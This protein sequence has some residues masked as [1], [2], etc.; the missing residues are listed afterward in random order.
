[1]KSLLHTLAP[2]LYVKDIYKSLDF[3]CDVLGFERPFIWGDPPGFAM[4]KREH[5]IIMLSQTNDTLKI[6][7]KKD[8]WDVYVWVSDVKFLHE[9][10]KNKGAHF[11]QDLILKEH[12]GNLE[13][14]VD[15]P[16]GYTIA[17]AE[18]ISK[19]SFF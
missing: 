10:F 14:I 6:Q 4:P 12:Y 16:D 15:D 7:P 5:I 17:F 18:G 3:Y 8:I 11:T 9:E 13:F 19:D 1:M 2:V